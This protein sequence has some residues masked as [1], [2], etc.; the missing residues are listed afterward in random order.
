[1]SKQHYATVMRPV[2]HHAVFACCAETSTPFTAHWNTNTTSQSRYAVLGTPSEVF[3]AITSHVV[4][5]HRDQ[6]SSAV[7]DAATVQVALSDNVLDG[8]RMLDEHLPGLEVT[9]AD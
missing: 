8:I 7:L 3:A 9:F 1:M 4:T 2:A 6:E 5:S